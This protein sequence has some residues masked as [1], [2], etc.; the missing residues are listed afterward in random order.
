MAKL[1][2]EYGFS[3]RNIAN[4]KKTKNSKYACYFSL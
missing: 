4:S 1:K 2:T 3:G